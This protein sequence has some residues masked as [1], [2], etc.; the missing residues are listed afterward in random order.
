MDTVVPKVTVFV[1]KNATGDALQKAVEDLFR[2]CEDGV[3]YRKGIEHMVEDRGYVGLSSYE[4]FLVE[5]QH[6]K[7]LQLKA[8]SEKSK[9]VEF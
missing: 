9:V 8:V 6:Q 7:E 5:V 3:K 2:M 1:D 4:Q